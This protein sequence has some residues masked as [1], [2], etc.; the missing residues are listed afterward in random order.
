MCS[1]EMFKYFKSV[2]LRKKI[3]YITAKEKLL[4]DIKP[5]TVHVP[6]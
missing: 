2:I 1:L 5:M 3:Q 6:Q 4:N